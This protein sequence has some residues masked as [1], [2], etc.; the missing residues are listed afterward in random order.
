MVAQMV[1]FLLNRGG[2]S[3]KWF[4]RKGDIQYCTVYCIGL[5]G[6]VCPNKGMAELKRM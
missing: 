3:L 5:M 4:L 6:N 1:F 2:G